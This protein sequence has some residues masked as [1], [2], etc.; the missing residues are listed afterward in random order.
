MRLNRLDLPSRGS[1]ALRIALVPLGLCLA[2]WLA[3]PARAAPD[4]PP[5]ANALR[6]AII[7]IPKA[8]AP[9]VTLQTTVYSP[10]GPGP[11][12][13]VVINHGKSPG[14]PRTHPRAR[15]LAMART[16]V[17][18]GYLVA[19]PM[20]QG[21]AGSGGRYV[22]TR[23]D[24]TA[25]A[26]L[27]AD[28]IQSAL[29]HLRQRPDVDPQ[30]VLL[31]GQ[32]LGGL[33]T[34]A[35]A[36]RD[37]AGV[38]GVLNFAGGVRNNNCPQ[39]EASLTTT[40]ETLGR[41]TRLPSLWFYGHN[42]TLWSPALID[43]LLAGYTRGGGPARMV[44]YGTWADDAHKLFGNAAGLAVWWPAASAYLRERGLPHQP[45]RRQPLWEHETPPPRA[46]VYAAINSVDR[47]PRVG[48]NGREGYRKFLASGMPRAYAIGQNGG[49]AWS[50]TNP[51]AMATALE[52][53]Q[54]NNRQEPCALYA[55][56]DSVVWTGQYAPASGPVPASAAPAAQEAALQP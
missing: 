18:M 25:M 32:S 6:E 38:Q 20:R 19:I 51:K 28:D 33:A 22:S 16:F 37:P 14:D 42:D 24:F 55:V 54:D 17:E 9:G 8:A 48:S 23:C 10:D 34:L 31:I 53:C 12:P 41:N 47:L 11:F 45:L 30:R 2:S 39:W 26:M 27:Q 29:E 36:T 13:V 3:T 1:H 46:T 52:R 49:W 35:L 21:F 15:Y 5:L 7:D 56:D 40:F 44:N 43:A 50:G 4:E